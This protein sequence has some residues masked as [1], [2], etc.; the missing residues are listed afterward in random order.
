M[1]VYTGMD[2]RLPLREVAAHARRA[3]A[4]GFDG[5]HVA[6]TVHDAFAAA[7]LALEHT[8]RLVVR[9][10][11]ALA[12]VRS[13]LLTAYGAWDLARF[14]GGRFQLGLGSQ[15][16]QNIED[17]YGMPWSPPV[18]RMRDYVGAVRAAFEAFR[19]GEPPAYEGPHHRLTRMQPYFNPGPDP[20]TVA[21]RILLGGVGRAMCALAG[22]LADG[23]VTHPTNSGPRWLATVARPALAEGIARAALP[24]TV[25]LVAGTQLIAG[26]DRAALD[27]ERERQR[28]LFAFLYSTP[29]YRATLDLYGWGELQDRLR[30]MVR[31]DDW[32]QLAR[33]VTDEVLDTLVPM[34][35]Y[36]ELP[37]L[38]TER[39]GGLADAVTVPLP[40][41]PAD[42]ARIRDVVLALR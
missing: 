2:P 15:V 3:E 6:E 23:L 41:D 17:R 1:R 28:R 16:R 18:A 7:L 30:V 13:P 27:A 34:A 40:V 24:R 33:H 36:E 26:P 9:T 12:F 14:S 37:A 10:S 8:E 5:L 4:A 11:V 25:E 35:V 19:T 20:D 32:S 31:R 38:I 29:A 21:P 39:W 22:E 42:D